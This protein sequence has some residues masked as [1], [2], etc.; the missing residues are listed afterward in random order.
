MGSKCVRLLPVNTV[1]AFPHLETLRKKSPEHFILG[2]ETRL[3]RAAG[4]CG[5]LAVLRAEGRG[6]GLAGSGVEHSVESFPG[7]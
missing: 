7:D 2:T 5:E 3:R 4:Q 1:F 6:S